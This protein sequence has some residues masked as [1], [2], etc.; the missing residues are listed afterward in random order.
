VGLVERRRDLGRDRRRRG[1]LTLQLDNPKYERFSQE[2]AQGRGQ[3][4]A[5]HLA[6]YRGGAAHASR[7]ASNGKI[8]ARVAELQKAGADKAEVTVAGVLMELWRIAT[9]DPRELVEHRIGCC[10]HCW[11]RDHRRQETPAERERRLVQWL[12]DQRAAEG[13]PLEDDF[14]EFDEQ[15]GLGFNAT[16]AA[17]PACPECFGEG[18]GRAVFKDTA[19]IS[20]AAAALY[21]GVKVTKDGQEVRLQDKQGALAKVGQHLGM[22]AERRIN[23]DVT[24]EEF[25]ASLDAG[26]AAGAGEAEPPPD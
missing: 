6:G 4:E 21:G 23:T 7:L 12:K 8:V 5:Y 22:F 3:L 16:R 11:G 25:L 18:V 17:N 1:S 9:A 2:L 26:P 14:R 24:L 13:K 19:E 15:G 20:P 10:R